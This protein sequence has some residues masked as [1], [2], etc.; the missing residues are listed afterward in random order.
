[1]A[2]AVEVHA[3]PVFNEFEFFGEQ[4]RMNH[5]ADYEWEMSEFA[6][7]A[8]G[9]GDVDLLSG[10]AAVHD[11][12]KAIVH[13]GDWERFRATAKK[14]KATAKDDLMP[15]VVKAFTQQTG[16][17]TSRPSVS[18]GGPKRTKKKSA[19]AGTSS[20]RVVRRLEKKGRP[21]LAL[22]VSMAEETRSAA[23]A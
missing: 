3:E 16:R 21:D 23:S 18:S 6:S 10:A 12:V 8:K 4:F 5:P 9:G 7:A 14:N 19:S 2:D 20:S 1:M 17:P 15:L 22:M 13:P 11:F